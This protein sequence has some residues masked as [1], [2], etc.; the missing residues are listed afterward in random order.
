MILLTLGTYPLSFER[1]VRIVDQGLASGDINEEIFAQIGCSEY[2][3]R[4]M[5]YERIL[6]KQVFEDILHRSTGIIGHAG[7]GTISLALQEGKPILVFPRL[8]RYREI[9]NDHQLAAARKFEEMGH[10]LAAYTPE[11][12]YEK[13][14]RLK[15]F[16]PE[17]RLSSPE[18]VSARVGGFLLGL[19]FNAKKG[20]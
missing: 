14:S 7:M 6:E 16:V 2:C 3:P 10:V 15:E 5:P 20:R 9:V 17:P 12:V 4:H 11:D 8:A 18:S 1:L 13:I 19:G